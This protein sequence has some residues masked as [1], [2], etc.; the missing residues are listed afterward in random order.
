MT[1][2]AVKVTLAAPVNCFTKSNVTPLMI[3]KPLGGILSLDIRTISLPAWLEI[4][5]SMNVLLFV[6]GDKPK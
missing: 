3:V 4:L 6:G 1:S 5:M 2:F